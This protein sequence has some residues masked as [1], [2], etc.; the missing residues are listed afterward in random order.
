[1][2]P[3]LSHPSRWSRARWPPK[4]QKHE[5]GRAAFTAYCVSY[6]LCRQHDVDVS[7]YDFSQLPLELRPDDPQGVRAILTEI[8]DT[9]DQIS[10]RMQRV[11]SPKDKEQ[12]R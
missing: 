1:M 3:S 9:A 4:C 2:D 12:G 7:G 8:R 6:L 10:L 5:R 11:L